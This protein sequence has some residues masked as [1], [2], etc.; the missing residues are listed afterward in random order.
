MSERKPFPIISKNRFIDEQFPFIIHQTKH[1]HRNK[2]PAHG[3]DFVELVYVVSGETT[4]WFEGN[5]YGIKAGDIFIINPGEVHMYEVELGQEIEIINC[6]FLPSLIKDSWLKELGVSESMDYYY[7]HPFLDEK[8]RF[9]H[10]VNLDEEEAMRVLSM[11]EL[12]MRESDERLPGYATLIRLQLV[13]LLILLSRYYQQLPTGGERISGSPARRLAQ[14][15]TGYLERY[16]DQ[17]VNQTALAEL[18]NI[19]SRQMNRTF[20]QET[21]LTIVEMIHQIRMAKAKHLLR[22]TDEKIITIAG[23]VG[24]EDPAFFTKLFLRHEGCSPGKYREKR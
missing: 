1:N 17:K 20:K 5:R 4:H 18:Y 23:L 10:R 8:E 16:Y 21:G 3:H 13:E 19:S 22:E 12:M 11:L 9:H 6:L 2:P 7:V 14:R 15:I 24:Y